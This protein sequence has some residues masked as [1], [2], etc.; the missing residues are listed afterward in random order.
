M[1]GMRQ[2]YVRGLVVRDASDADDAPIRVVAATEGRK[3]DGI[4]LRMDTVDL[5]RFRANPVIMYGHEYWGRDGLPI[6]RAERVEVDGARLVEDLRFDPDDDFAA[7]VER[8]L[9]AGFLNAVSIGFNAY[10]IGEDGVPARWELFETSVVPLPMDPAALVE[11]GRARGL[12]AM[13]GELRAGKV[14][15]A[16]NKG[17]VEDAIAALSAL[18]DAAEPADDEDRTGVGAATRLDAARRRLRLA[19]I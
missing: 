16:K 10:D 13:L 4:D 17:L 12:A 14:L 8:K 19:G 7:T 11:A 9:R 3:P 1:T 18:L 5:D 2:T 6:G 15:S